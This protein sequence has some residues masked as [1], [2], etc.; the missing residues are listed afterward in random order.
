MWEWSG[1]V[2]LL[3]YVWNQ[4]YNDFRVLYLTAIVGDI[5]PIDGIPKEEKRRREQEALDHMCKVLGG[6]SRGT[7]VF[8]HSFF[9]FLRK[10]I[11]FTC[12]DSQYIFNN[13]AKEIAEL[14]TEYEANSSPE[15]KFVKDLDKVCG[16]LAILSF[17]DLFMRS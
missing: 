1:V 3:I 11:I 13:E 7:L 6:G 10:Q 17:N 12:I 14:W 8:N 2:L 15:A 16:C 4:M 9:L 5:T